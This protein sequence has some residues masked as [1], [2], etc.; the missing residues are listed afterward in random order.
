MGESRVAQVL[1][2]QTQLKLPLQWEFIGTLQSNKA[3][4][5]VELCQRVA[6]VDRPKLLRA[7]ARASS[8]QEKR[9]AILLQINPLGETSQG[10]VAVQDAPALLEAALEETSLKVEGLMC[11]APLKGGEKT[12]RSCFATLR[13]LRDRLQAD[14]SIALPELSAG[15]SGDLEAAILEGSTQLRVGTALFGKPQASP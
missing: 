14:F 7:L 1:E 3:K 8:Q 2:K 11:L 13:T 15:M 10:G 6:S 5:A 9:L 4:K 12:Q